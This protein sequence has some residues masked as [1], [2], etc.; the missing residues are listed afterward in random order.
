MEMMGSGWE[1][2]MNTMPGRHLALLWVM[3]IVLDSPCLFFMLS[4]GIGHITLKNY[5]TPLAI[6]EHCRAAWDQAVYGSF[7]W[8]CSHTRAGCDS[9][10]SH[11][12]V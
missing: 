6:T 8:L 11:I 12:P 5:E 1:D 7:L 9:H 4:F 10:T 3:M 2:M